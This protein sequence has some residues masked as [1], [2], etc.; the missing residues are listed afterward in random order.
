MSDVSM[1]ARARQAFEDARRQAKRDQIAA[2]LTGRDTRMVPFELVRKQLRQQSALYQGVAQVPLSQIVGSVGRYTEL[3]RHFLP[4]SDDMR[5]R[6]MR[7]TSLAMT[8]QGWPP[9]DLYKVS[10]VYFVK[11][12]NHRVSAARQLGYPTIE[13]HVWEYPGTV[14][15]DP[16][17]DLDEILIRFGEKAFMETTGLDQVYPDH[18]I[19]FTTPGRYT[20]LRAQI[21]DLQQKLAIIDERDVPYSAA[22]A[23]WY[24]MIYL[25]VVQIIRDSDLLEAFPGRTEA[26]LFVWM[27]LMR[28]PLQEA[29]GDF[30]NLADLA[31][32]LAA[33]YREGSLD[34]LARQVK[35]LLGNN[36][37]PPLEEEVA[38]ST[39][40]EPS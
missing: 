37:L 32:L 36:T 2:R 5:E 25:P 16:E 30:D 29:Y 20:E 7:V 21:A 11:D 17:S 24:E 38:L 19:R 35:R 18:G 10:N 34:K 13:A 31:R 15:I 22:V 14:Q 33:K 26:D 27:S 8:Q 1:R 28:H 40:T 39:K 9:I 3:T 12:G 23:A 4:L 6:W